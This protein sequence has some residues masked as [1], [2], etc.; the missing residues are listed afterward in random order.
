MKQ[1][2][3]SETVFYY[4]ILQSFPKFNF[5]TNTVQGTVRVAKQV[6]SNSQRIR[7]ASTRAVTNSFIGRPL[8]QTQPQTGKALCE[9]LSKIWVDR[10]GTRNRSISVQRIYDIAQKQPHQ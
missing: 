3:V 2:G 5:W 6:Y 8:L 10:G 4:F 7:S 9:Y 1:W